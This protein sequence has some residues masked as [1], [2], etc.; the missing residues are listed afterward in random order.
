MRFEKSL[1]TCSDISILYLAAEVCQANPGRSGGV[2][3]ANVW[4]S[5]GFLV[6]TMG[7]CNLSGKHRLRTLN[8]FGLPCG[9]S[10]EL[11][12]D[13]RILHWLEVIRL[14]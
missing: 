1:C 14:F 3:F 6:C 11:I 7:Q 5:S 10:V 13:V 9:Y 2:M 8:G 12:L 4:S